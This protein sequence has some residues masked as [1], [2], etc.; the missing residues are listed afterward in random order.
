MKQPC[1]DTSR[2]VATLNPKTCCTS[3]E[4]YEHPEANERLMFLRNMTCCPQSSMVHTSTQ[5][6]ERILSTFSFTVEGSTLRRQAALDDESTC[7]TRK[8][9]MRGSGVD[10]ERSMVSQVAQMNLD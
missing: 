5:Q 10:D 2:N 4:S 8:G 7:S 6:N 1:S 3:T 9:R